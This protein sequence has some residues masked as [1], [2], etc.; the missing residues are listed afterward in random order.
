MS[1]ECEK[2]GENT[3]ECTCRPAPNPGTT[4]AIER[5]CLCPVI[6]NHHGRGWKGVEGVFV[7]T[8][9]CPVHPMEQK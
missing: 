5:G 2:C 8:S 3:L 6:D 4:E 1:G 9:G 7:Y